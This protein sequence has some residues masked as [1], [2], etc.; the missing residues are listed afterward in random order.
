M[1]K[2][3]GKL[4]YK[5]AFLT[6]VFTFGGIYITFIIMSFIDGGNAV[7]NLFQYESSIGGLYVNL[8]AMISVSYSKFANEEFVHK[9]V[10]WLCLIS[11]V[12][13]ITI[14]SQAR[15]MTE[16]TIS[17]V[18]RWLEHPILSV[19]L[20]LIFVILIFLI[21]MQKEYIVCIIYRKKGK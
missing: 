12:V 8:F 5:E 18:V 10:Y 7:D 11:F 21:S 3:T 13:I 17:L 4:R 9:V 19:V 2:H 15:C 16:N 1:R 6:T 14:Y 20:Q